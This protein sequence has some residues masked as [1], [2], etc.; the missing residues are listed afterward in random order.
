MIDP[1]S[2]AR[3]ALFA[4]LDTARLEAVAQLF[5]EESFAG[6]ARVLREGISGSAFYVITDG[7]AEIRIGGETRTTLGAGEF[8]GEVSVL[9]GEAPIADV[10][11]VGDELRCAVLDGPQ[12]RPFLLDHPAIAVRMLESVS[13]RLRNASLWAG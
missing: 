13:R 8:F 2:L 1:Q 10:V 11:A 3:L 7:R 12:V 6:G 4:D 9:T 5:D